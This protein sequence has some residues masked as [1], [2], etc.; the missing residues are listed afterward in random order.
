MRFTFANTTAALV[1]F[2]WIL[3]YSAVAEEKEAAHSVVKLLMKQAI[4]ENSGHEVRMLTVAYAPGVSSAAHTHPGCIFAYVL[5]GA[6][7]C[8]LDDEKPVRYEAGQC[9]YEKP[10]QVHR[11][12]KNASDKEP[13]KLLV[14]FI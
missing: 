1:I 6:V 5:E 12:S 13:A 14:F 7:I 9:W 2:S 10:G 4:P 8:Q 11:V 3:T